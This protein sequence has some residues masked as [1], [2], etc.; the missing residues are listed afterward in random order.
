MLHPVRALL[1]A[2]LAWAALIPPMPAQVQTEV[3]L[4]LVIAVD[5][6]C[7]M[8]T[9]EQELQREGFAEAIRTKVVREIAETPQL[10]SLVQPAQAQATAN[11]L[12]GELRRQR[13]MDN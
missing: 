12:A 7:S 5:I 11:C 13:R 2:A 3:D 4:A 6:S 8:D 10:Q 9:D 1:L